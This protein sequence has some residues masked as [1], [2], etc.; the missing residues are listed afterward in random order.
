MEVVYKSIK[1][2]Q[3]FDFDMT[4]DFDLYIIHVL[5]YGVS[6]GRRLLPST[7]RI[8]DGNSILFRYSI[9]K[10]EPVVLERTGSRFVIFC[11]L[12]VR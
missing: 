1:H 9:G 6:V 3:D 5:G 11:L 4:F 10:L 8:L 12:V 2:G 7:S